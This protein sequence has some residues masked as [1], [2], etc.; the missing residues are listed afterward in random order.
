MQNK[1]Q[2]PIEPIKIIFR[3][4]DNERKSQ[5]I[6]YIFVGELA[7]RFEHILEKIENLNLYSTLM[8][9]TQKDVKELTEGFGELWITNFFNIYH[10]SSFINEIKTNKSMKKEILTKY[11]EKW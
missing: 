10:I 6:M 9:L 7:K 11:D 8:K 1:M 4:K 2:Y 3:Y 5:N